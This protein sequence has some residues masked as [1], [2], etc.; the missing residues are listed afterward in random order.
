MCSHIRSGRAHN[1]LEFPRLLFEVIPFWIGG[2][3]RNLLLDRVCSVP[4]SSVKDLPFAL[5]TPSPPD[6]FVRPAD[7]TMG[8]MIAR[9]FCVLSVLLSYALPLPAPPSIYLGLMIGPRKRG[10]MQTPTPHSALRPPLIH[11]QR[12]KVT[13]ESL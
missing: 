2:M 7:P 11:P 10:S 13:I 12:A 5:E 6:G 4:P 8:K 3:L 9:M 1:T